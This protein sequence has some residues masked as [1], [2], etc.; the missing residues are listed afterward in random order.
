MPPRKFTPPSYRRRLGGETFTRTK[1]FYN[2]KTATLV[3]GEHRTEGKRARLV[4]ATCPKGKRAYVV[5]VKA[6]RRR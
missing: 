5:Y 3:A 1:R 4:R 6:R 2:R